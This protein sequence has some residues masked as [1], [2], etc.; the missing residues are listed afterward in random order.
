MIIKYLQILALS[1]SVLA[2]S[3]EGS[4]RRYR[5]FSLLKLNATFVEVPSSHGTKTKML[6]PF[7][8]LLLVTK[9][10][11]KHRQAWTSREQLSSVDRPRL[12]NLGSAKFQKPKTCRSIETTADNIAELVSSIVIERLLEIGFTTLNVCLT[13]IVLKGPY[14]CEKDRSSNY[15]RLIH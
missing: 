5:L 6:Q 10:S 8:R 7:C 9:L 13:W 1:D 2:E 14:P 4:N 3:V 11:K 12:W 15:S